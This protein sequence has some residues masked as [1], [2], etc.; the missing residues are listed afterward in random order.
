MI[1]PVD[2]ESF[3]GTNQTVALFAI[4]ARFWASKQK[5]VSAKD[6]PEE[7]LKIPLLLLPL[8]LGKQS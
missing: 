5:T 6:Y 1:M 4:S 3:T 2:K 8:V 7:R